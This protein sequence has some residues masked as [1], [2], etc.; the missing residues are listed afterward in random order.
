MNEQ[1]YENP[2]LN[3]A[4]MPIA[5][6][7]GVT[8]AASSEPRDAASGAAVGTAFGAALGT[9]VGTASVADTLR[10]TTRR[11]VGAEPD[12]APAR[13]P[14]RR[15]SAVDGLRGVAV[16]AVLLH[17]TGVGG[18]WFSWTG[19]GVDVLLVLAGFLTTLPLLRGATATGR[20][21]VRAYLARRTKRLLPTLLLSLTLSLILTLGWSDWLDTSSAQAPLRLLGLTA[22]S[23]LLWSL[24][25]SALCVLARR[26]LTV[27]ALVASLLTCAGVAM[28]IGVAHETTIATQTIAFPAGAAAACVVHLAERGGRTLSRR[29]ATLL[30]TTGFSAAVS[31]TFAGSGYHD[32]RYPLATAAVTALLTATLCTD[33]GPLARLLSTDLLTEVGRMSATLFLL[34]L[35]VYTLL[36]HGQPDL[37]SL[38]LFLVGTAVTWFLSLL[39]H[40]L[41]TERLASH[42]WRPDD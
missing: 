29:A 24:L 26:R 12:R 37:S 15:Y 31:A 21:G 23:V 17:D 38:S 9:A 40:Y 34:H 36:R 20:T 39:T 16:L 14:G 25:L 11:P 18:R 22:G 33:R 2:P 5:W 35:P 41:L 4:D 42:R 6:G 1:R 3:P 7:G 19:A 8:A 28:A 27:P 32:V 10:L 13:D 30:T